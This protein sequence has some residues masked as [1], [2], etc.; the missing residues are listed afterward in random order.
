LLRQ[1]E[2]DVSLELEWNSACK[3]G[4]AGPPKKAMKALQIITEDEGIS[5]EALK[6]YAELFKHPLSQIQVEALSALFGWPTPPEV[7]V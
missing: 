5:Q 4:V 7:L 3:I 2:A 1:D 6:A